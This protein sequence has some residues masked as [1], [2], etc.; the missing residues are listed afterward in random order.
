MFAVSKNI[1]SLVCLKINLRLKI[2]WS[3]PYCCLTNITSLK[4]AFIEYLFLKNWAENNLCRLM[5]AEDRSL[6]SATF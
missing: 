5:Q 1:H 3:L 2:P 6:V 4:L